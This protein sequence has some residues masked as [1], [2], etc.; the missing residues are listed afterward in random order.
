MKLPLLPNLGNTLPPTKNIQT[1]I[2]S[3]PSRVLP[4]LNEAVVSISKS[5]KSFQKAPQKKGLSGVKDVDLKILSELN[6]RYL[7]SFCIADKHVNQM[8]K[9]EHFW[10]NRFISRFGNVDKPTITW[11][12]QYLTVISHLDKWLKNPWKYF[13][14]ISWPISHPPYTVDLN[15][16]KISFSFLQLG[17]EITLYF[18]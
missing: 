11:R 18:L 2:P 6:D 13:D 12:K 17:K 3:S 16:D 8:C 9:D 14:K 10:R 5:M 4:P 7:F 1:L 15:K